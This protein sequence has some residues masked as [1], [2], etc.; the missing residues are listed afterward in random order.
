MAPAEL[1]RADTR[2]VGR[3]LPRGSLRRFFRFR[4]FFSSQFSRYI[5]TFIFF[6]LKQYS[7][8]ITH[9]IDGKTVYMEGANV[10][11]GQV[12]FPSEAALEPFPSDFNKTSEMN[13]LLRLE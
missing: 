3:A 7:E 2:G 6:A 13:L 12:T 1:F 10:N 9:T 8:L 5:S 11:H 4:F